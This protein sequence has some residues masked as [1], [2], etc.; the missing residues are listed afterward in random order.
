MGDLQ[1][2]SENSLVLWKKRQEKLTEEVYPAVNERVASLKKKMVEAFCQKKN[3]AS[4]EKF[5]PGI[6]VMMYD[7]TRKS[8]WDPVYEGPFSIVRRNKGGAYVTASGKL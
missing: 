6:P 3:I 8:K 5:L 7:A 2:H 4:E 1:K